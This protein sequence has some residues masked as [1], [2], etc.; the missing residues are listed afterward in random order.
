M[1]GKNIKSILAEVAGDVPLDIHQGVCHDL[2]LM[3]I[4][5]KIHISFEHIKHHKYYFLKY[6][7]MVLSRVTSHYFRKKKL[8]YCLTQT[9]K[10]CNKSHFFK[11]NTNIEIV[12]LPIL[13][14]YSSI[15]EASEASKTSS[16]I[17]SSAES[18]CII[19]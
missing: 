12:W 2:V 5:K 11:V 7:I 3:Q 4:Q 16:L 19:M 1:Y 13:D 14:H 18:W 6:L 9:L 17:I 15:C 10:L 8:L